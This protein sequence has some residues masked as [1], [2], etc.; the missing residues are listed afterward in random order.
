MQFS[1]EPHFMTLLQ[2]CHVS[3]SS[4]TASLLPSICD[5]TVGVLFPLFLTFESFVGSAMMINLSFTCWI[6]T[7]TKKVYRGD[8]S[9][10][11]RPTSR[12]NK[13]IGATI[14]SL[15]VIAIGPCM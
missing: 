1:L 2:L 4:L 8:I 7:T 14:S 6:C 11:Y 10:R 15:S 3:V 12:H 5:T 9:R 13:S